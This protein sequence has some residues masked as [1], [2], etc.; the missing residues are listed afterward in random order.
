MKK[1]YVLLTFILLGLSISTAFSQAFEQGSN[2]ISAGY[3]LGTFTGSIFSVY[4]N[5]DDY[6]NKTLGPIYVKYGHAVSDKVEFGL[7]FGLTQ[8]DLQFTD[9]GTTV[10]IKRVAWSALA[11][12]KLHFGDNDRFDPYW[13]IGLG[14][15]TATWDFE[16]SDPSYQPTTVKSVVPLGFETTFGARYLV[17]DNIGIYAELGI[18]QSYL[19][20]GLVA[21]L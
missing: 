1:N 20:G 10:N 12:L 18:A 21:K 5:Y 19:Q 6:S 7:N 13:S 17:T 16:Y 3:G 2:Y 15:R 4:E 11:S 9:L 14:Y 8:H